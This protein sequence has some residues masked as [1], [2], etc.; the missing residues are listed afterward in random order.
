[1]YKILCVDDDRNIVN[2]L[3]LILRKSGYYVESTCSGREALNMLKKNKYDLTIVDY[4]MPGVNGTE[5]LNFIKKN[6]IPTEVIILTGY[7]TISHAVESIKSGA[8]DYILKPFHKE[9]LLTRI[10]KVFEYK[11]VQDENLKL[12]NLLKKNYSFKNLISS[13]YKMVKVF[14]KIKK[15][16][17]NDSTILITGE[18]GTGK[19]EVAKAIHYSGIYREKIFNV[20]DCTSINPNL[21]ESELFGYRKGAF[22]GAI[23]EKM[24]LLKS[25]SG[26]TLFLD[27][28]AEI[29]VN[30][31]VKFLRALEQK[32][33]RPIGSTELERFNARIIAAT[34]RNLED[35]IKK[36]KFRQ[37]LYYRLNVVRIELPPLRERKEDIPLLVN[38]FLKK[39]N[40]SRALIKKVSDE[41]YEVFQAYNWPGN[42]RE[43]ENCIERAFALDV[44]DVIRLEDLP[45][46]L[47]TVSFKVKDSSEKSFSIKES[48]KDLILKSLKESN[49]DKK[50][51]AKMLG[52]SLAT[53]YRRLKEI[54]NLQ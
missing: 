20:V 52:I 49:G 43:L 4:K 19:E 12:K 21:I 22:T 17:N 15:V 39:Y 28:I 25:T 36:G 33:Y 8:T 46:H 5:I 48:E 29:P 42:I 1:M 31:Q 45:P 13:N 18:T 37:D 7:G 40:K 50:K 2:G 41:V 38:F 53:L 54:K 9:D 26:G 51:A 10:E 35:E 47:Q 24:G 34:S 14:E 11:K 27:E 30:I 3:S 16:A 23:T 32:E 44:R 6:K